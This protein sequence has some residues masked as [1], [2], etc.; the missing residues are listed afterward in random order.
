MSSQQRIRSGFNFFALFYDVA[1]YVFFGNSILKAQTYFLPQLKEKK[2]VLVFGGGTGKLLLELLR[3]NVA[4][5]Y[6]YVDI[7]DKMISKSKRRLAK[8]FP[9]K[10]NAV[11]FICGSVESIPSTEKFDLIITPCVLDCFTE[12]E[13]PEIMQQLKIHLA[14]NGEWLFIDFNIPEKQKSIAALKIRTMYFF[15]NV[16]CGLGVRK[17]PDFKK[18]FEKLNLKTK[19]EKYFLQG[20]MVARIYKLI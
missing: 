12:N 6:C 7:S 18:E 8:Y 11:N 5:K 10:I 13:L 1:S 17:L 16:I 2:N 9:E 20:L 4:E 14:E 19:N 3:R 15:F